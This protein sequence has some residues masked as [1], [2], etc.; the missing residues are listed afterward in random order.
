MTTTANRNS[1][2]SNYLTPA[3]NQAG[4]SN[5][6]KLQHN[7]NYESTQHPSQ[8]PTTPTTTTKKNIRYDSATCL[9]DSFETLKSNMPAFERFSPRQEFSRQQGGQR[10]R[11]LLSLRAFLFY[12]SGGDVVSLLSAYLKGNEGKK[13]WALLNPKLGEDK[14]DL[15]MGSIL[16]FHNSGDDNGHALRLVANHFTHNELRS[17]G[18]SVSDK[19]LATARRPFKPRAF[20]PNCHP[21]P[22]ETVELVKKFYEENTHPAGNRTCYDK[23]TQ[24]H[25]P[26]VCNNSPIKHLHQEFLNK[27]PEIKISGTKFWQLKPANV[28]PSKRK[29]DM[30]EY[31]VECEKLL[32]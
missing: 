22:V 3:G 11:T 17:R 20:P 29:I 31:C 10:Q 26:V 16:A 14:L 30:C 13:I 19:K 24:T 21:I 18:W 9:R 1:N 4:H 8:P 5:R 6:D 23:K 15:V 32:R 27:N 2:F 12:M 28:R 25:V 7:K